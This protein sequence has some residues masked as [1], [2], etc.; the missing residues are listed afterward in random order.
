M[1]NDLDDFKTSLRS[2]A[3]KPELANLVLTRQI[4]DVKLHA[5]ISPCTWMYEGHAF[6]I[7]VTM[8]GG[9]EV[10]MQNTEL[11]YADSA[12]ADVQKLLDAVKVKACKCKCGK[13]AF[14]PKTVKT[15]RAGKCESCF[16]SKLNEDFGKI[17][18][19]EAKE[20]EKENQKHRELG[21]T[22][23]AEAWIHAGGDD[24][25]ITLYFKGEP[26]QAS[27]MDLLRKK[28]C[29]LCTDFIILSL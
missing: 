17:F 23:K 16:M 28:G 20:E 8:V 1:N 22:F 9:G 14:D 19:E 21:F 15:N 2:K 25:L 6:Q 26:S 5:E 12:Q 7:C 27:V 29:K 10:Y 13:P 11:L 18:Q 4:G 3:L 24:E